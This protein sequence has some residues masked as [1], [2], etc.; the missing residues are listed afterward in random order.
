MI[1][2]VQL[3]IPVG[4]IWNDAVNCGLC[5]AAV[6]HTCGLGTT[7]YRFSGYHSELYLQNPRA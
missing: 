7:D 1:V 6:G 4:C 3:V 2:K 5:V